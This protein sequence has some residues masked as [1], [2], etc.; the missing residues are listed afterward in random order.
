MYVSVITTDQST[1]TLTVNINCYCDQFNSTNSF[2]LGRLF[3][4]PLQ[5]SLV[6]LCL[7]SVQNKAKLG[8]WRWTF[9][10]C[11][12]LWPSL[13]H[14]IELFLW[15]WGFNV[16]SFLRPSFFRSIFVLQ[17]CHRSIVRSLLFF[18]HVAYCFLLLSIVLETSWTGTPGNCPILP[19]QRIFALRC[20]VL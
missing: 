9:T 7:D 13:F 10:V 5:Q 4:S 12:F 20:H 11:S 6:I 3:T 16:C 19:Q 18:V 1:H 2:L 8:L 17:K 15:Q 14:W